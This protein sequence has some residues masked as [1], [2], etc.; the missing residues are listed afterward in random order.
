MSLLGSIGHL[1]AGS[2]LQE[3]FELM[4]ALNAV[5]HM[6]AG[7]ALAR[8]VRAHLIIDPALNAVVH[9]LA[10]KALARAV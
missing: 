9:M 1:M 5:V 7:E 10:G 2:G 6:L 8:A 4:Y 3:L